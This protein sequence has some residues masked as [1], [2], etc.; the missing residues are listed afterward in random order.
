ML[1][2]LR[3]F[4]LFL[5]LLCVL[6]SVCAT[7][8]FNA[9]N[10]FAGYPTYSGTSQTVAGQVLYQSFSTGTSGTIQGSTTSP[11]N[12]VAI[13]NDT[14]CASCSSLITYSFTVES[15]NNIM[16][17]TI[18]GYKLTLVSQSC[19]G[20]SS[21][22]PLIVWTNSSSATAA[23]I[24]SSTTYATVSGSSTAQFF[25]RGTDS[26]ITAAGQSPSKYY[27]PFPNY[28][29]G[30]YD[31]NIFQIMV[32]YTGVCTT[33]DQVYVNRYCP[34]TPS[35]PS[36]VHGDPE[37]TGL[38]GQDYQI[39]GIDGAVYN[40]ISD[41]YM[42]LNSRFIFLDGPRA[43]PIIPSTGVQSV[44]CWSHSGSYLGDL[45]LK[46]NMG[47]KVYIASGPAATGFTTVEVDGVTVQPAHQSA[48]LLSGTNMESG[49][50]TFLSS[51]EVIVKVGLFELEIENSDDF[52]NLRSVLVRGKNWP[53]LVKEQAH[54]LLGQTWQVRKGNGINAVIEGKVDDY[55]ILEDEVF[56]E[57]FM[58]NKFKLLSSE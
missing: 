6:P 37:F 42:Q 53:L 10:E 34:T 45:A 56:G 58:Y 28:K 25:Y 30:S 22:P 47:S 14:N 7:C 9:F 41:Q 48:L 16:T 20:C 49:S 44:A 36:T 12:V 35:G 29:C 21:Y 15:V 1:N 23:T 38:R 43:C 5:V 26:S 19:T 39:H 46:T 13:L 54:G 11:G 51:H 4:S 40:I 3:C 55:L 24:T 2:P 50:F 27:I 31:Q 33:Y 52:L 57:T 8:G 17:V 32:K 18:N